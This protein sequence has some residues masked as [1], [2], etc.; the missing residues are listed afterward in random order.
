MLGLLLRKVRKLEFD[1]MKN[2]NLMIS[3]LALSGFVMGCEKEP[4]YVEI[5]RERI[6]AFYNGTLKTRP[7]E[8][9]VHQPTGREKVAQMPVEWASL[10]MDDQT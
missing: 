1:Y 4:E 5:A 2:R 6:I 9:P 7:I 8:R 10:D 3:L